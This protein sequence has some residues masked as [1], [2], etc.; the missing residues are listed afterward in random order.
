MP[1][2]KLVAYILQNMSCKGEL[3]RLLR[4]GDISKNNTK[5]CPKIHE[6]RLNQKMYNLYW[7]SPQT[8]TVLRHSVT[9][10]VFKSNRIYYFISLIFSNLTGFITFQKLM[11]SFKCCR[12][13]SCHL[14][15]SVVLYKPAI[16]EDL[17]RH[18]CRNFFVDYGLKFNKLT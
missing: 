5:K 1:F 10:P 11:M 12:M 14:A 16:C 4:F 2:H 13:M 3:Y 17:D 8:V 6:S 7:L 9:F 15:T 18:S